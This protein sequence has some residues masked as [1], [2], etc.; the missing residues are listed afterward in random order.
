MFLMF[1]LH[2]PDVLPTGDLGVR[3]AAMRAYGL[4]APARARGA[5]G[6]GRAVAPVPHARVPV[7]VAEPGQRARCSDLA[8][9]MRRDEEA[10]ARGAAGR[11]HVLGR[12]LRRRRRRRRRTRSSRCPTE[13]GL[14]EKVRAAAAAPTTS[15][16]PSADGKTLQQ[17]AEEVKG[18]G[19]DR[20]RA[21]QL[22]VHGRREPPRVR[23][24][25]RPGPV[26][27]RPDRR[28]RRARRP[29]SP[30]RARSRRPP[31]CSITEGR[32][33]SRQAAEETDPFAAVYEAQVPFD[34]KGPWAVLVGHQERQHVRRR[35]RAGAGEHEEGG[36]DPG[37]RRAA[38]RRWR[39]T[40]WP[41]SRAT[42]SCSTRACRRATCTSDSFDEVLGKKPVAL[43]F[44]TPQLCQSRVCGPV[45]D[46]ALQLKAKYGDQIEFIHQEVYV[47]NDPNAGL[48]PP[49]QAFHLRDRAVAVRGRRRRARSPRGSRAR[50]G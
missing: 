15:D 9:L 8:T 49:L 46:V 2:R 3:N 44:S 24:D 32:Y 12:G 40:R 41:R 7:P 6:A 39:P 25:R 16:F 31:T 45:T 48:R 50:S 30:P 47:D 42:R 29:T 43:L 33:R 11:R 5:G 10:R 19:I 27:L 18:G 17:V 34:K 23:R 22:G 1:T 28:L 21:R 14:Q 37:R 4:D 36:P 26:R 35:A 20:G 38:R 13:G